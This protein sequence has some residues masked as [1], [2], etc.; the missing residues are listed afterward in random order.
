VDQLVQDGAA[1][2][3][4]NGERRSP[5]TATDLRGRQVSAAAQVPRGQVRDDR[6][7]Q[8]LGNRRH[9]RLRAASAGEDGS[10]VV[11]GGRSEYARGSVRGCLEIGEADG[12]AKSIGAHRGLRADVIACIVNVVQRTDPASLNSRSEFIPTSQPRRR[13]WRHVPARRRPLRQKSRPT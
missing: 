7:P 10:R 8:G 9:P 3:A 4:G 5:R 6:C 1:G 2:E 11:D 13:I 12:S